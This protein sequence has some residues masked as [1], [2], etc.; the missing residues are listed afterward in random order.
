MQG[1]LEM[2]ASSQWFEI[3][4]HEVTGMAHHEH[5]LTQLEA[6]KALVRVYVKTFS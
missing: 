4:A 1:R 3:L 5:C 2:G 6:P